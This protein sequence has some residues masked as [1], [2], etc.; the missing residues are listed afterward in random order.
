MITGAWEH[1][2][3]AEA[4]EALK[5]VNPGAM[6]GDTVGNPGETAARRAVVAPNAERVGVLYSEAGLRATRAW[7]DQTFG[8]LARSDVHPRGPWIALMLAGLVTLAWPLAA[9]FP[10]RE[11][12]G[13]HLRPGGFALSLVA[14][15]IVAPLLLRLVTFFLPSVAAADYLA[16]HFLVQG[17]LMVGLLWRADAMPAGWAGGAFL[18]LPVAIYG[19][20]AL[21]GALDAYVTSTLP[22]PARA[23][24][25]LKILPGAVVWM[26]AEATLTEGG[27]AS[28]VRVTLVRAVLLGSVA[29]AVVLGPA[30]QGLSAVALPTILGVLVVFGLVGGWV[31]R[32]TGQ[33]L[34]GGIAG[35]VVLAWALGVTVPL[36]AAA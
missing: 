10:L 4:L 12:R 5:L 21:G 36:V 9:L 25:V 23:V 8:R 14:P 3:R 28:W 18:A 15:A 16:L 6:E 22:H 13:G 20:V 32:R 30:R 17:A 24:L 7:L 1:A 27:R 11:A 35:G 2:R 33:P 26:L 19:L 34:A 29:F 31:G